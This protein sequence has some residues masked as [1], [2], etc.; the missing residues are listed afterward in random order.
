MIFISS[1]IYSDL[2]KISPS[3]LSQ[4]LNFM[5]PHVLACDAL[6]SNNKIVKTKSDEEV[7]AKVAQIYFFYL[8]QFVSQME[9]N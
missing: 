3:E 9:N 6:V 2:K 5:A 1:W 4:F 7:C 8:K